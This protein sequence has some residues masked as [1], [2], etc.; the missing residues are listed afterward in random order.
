MMTIHYN[1]LY[2]DS[3][4]ISF[5]EPQ[6]LVLFVE[7]TCLCG[8]CACYTEATDRS[9][10]KTKGKWCREC[11]ENTCSHKFCTEAI[12]AAAAAAAARKLQELK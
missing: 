10:C 3:S 4:E 2:E 11:G 1:K 5:I 7:Q 9:T 12:T 6:I 8:L